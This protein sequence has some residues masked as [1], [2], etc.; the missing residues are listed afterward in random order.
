MS[1]Q[2]H[3]FDAA[4]CSLTQD[5]MSPNGVSCLSPTSSNFSC[6]GYVVTTAQSATNNRCIRDLSP[7]CMLEM[8]RSSQHLWSRWA[9]LAWSMAHSRPTTVHNTRKEGSS[10]SFVPRIA[11]PIGHCC[12]TRRSLLLHP[13]ISVATP[14]DL[15]CYTRRSLL[16]HPS[17]SVATPVDLCC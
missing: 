4:R 12:Y 14:V 2:F 11:R 6:C 13:S 7:I 16:L 15:C 9:G 8:A 10:P 17:I 5:R 3:G 1:E